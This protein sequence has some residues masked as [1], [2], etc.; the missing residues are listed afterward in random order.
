M[1]EPTM[2]IYQGLCVGRRNKNSLEGSFK[3]IFRYCGVDVYMN[4]KQNSPYLKEVNI[5]RR[6]S[7]NIRNKN[8]MFRKRLAK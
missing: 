7:G 5:L 6:G 4:I 8:A 1:S 2:N 3:F